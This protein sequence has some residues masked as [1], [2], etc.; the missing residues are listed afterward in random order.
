MEREIISS[1]ECSILFSNI[2]TLLPV[3][4]ELLNKL[5]SVK[6]PNSYTQQSFIYNTNEN[7]GKSVLS[8]N[9]EHDHVTKAILV[10]NSTTGEEAV[11]YVIRRLAHDEEQLLQFQSD[12]A[13]CVLLDKF[14]SKFF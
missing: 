6:E 9:V 13:F 5:K 12:Y 2:E 10:D 8:I 4:E 3:N 7:P 1:K 14:T 11:D